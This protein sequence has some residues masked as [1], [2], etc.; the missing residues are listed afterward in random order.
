[1]NFDTIEIFGSSVLGLFACV[2]DKYCLISDVAGRKV[3]DALTETLEVPLIR[4]SIVNTNFVGLFAVGNSKCLLVPEL[5]KEFS[6][7][8]PVKVINSNNTCF[9]NLILCNDNGAVVSPL[10]RKS[11]PQISEALGVRAEVGTIAG[12]A[13][14]GSCG[15]ANSR[16][17]LAHPDIKKEEAE[18][19][20]K[21]LGVT[22]ERGT[23]N[24]G[25]PY[26]GACALVNSK[27]ALVSHF[28]LPP[29]LVRLRETLG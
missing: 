13:I 27:G 15:L 21:V 8:I 20:E 22:V 12:L 7:N 5:A 14:V 3:T 18:L 29:E 19:I 1:M 6:P 11:V 24:R 10:L 16:G 25:S 17:C 28:T 2:T 26:V 4:K 23:L 9:G